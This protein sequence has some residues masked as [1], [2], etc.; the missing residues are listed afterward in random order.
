[1]RG[2]GRSGE[3]AGAA[4]IVVVLALLFAD[5]LL[6]TGTFYIRDLV[7]GAHPSKSMFRAAVTAGELPQW[8]RWIGGGQPFA[9]NPAHQVF[10]PPAW[11]VLLPDLT[12]GF[13]LFLLLHLFI[14]ALGMYALLRSMDAGPAASAAAA[15]S[16]ALSA[17]LAVQDLIP[18]MTALACLPWTCLFTRPLLRDRRPRH[19]AFA[20]LL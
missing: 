18:L 7:F 15:I 5:V 17:V 3:R 13:N 11:L 14:G 20:P 4:G 1:M 12:Y 16:F 6:G 10:Y 2:S 8:N 9:A 19:F